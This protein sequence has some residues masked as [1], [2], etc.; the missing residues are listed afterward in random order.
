LHTENGRRWQRD[1]SNTTTPLRAVN[2]YNDNGWAVGRDGVILRYA[3][4]N[5]GELRTI[6]GNK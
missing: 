1:L 3:G 5:A 4:N 6:L 2:F